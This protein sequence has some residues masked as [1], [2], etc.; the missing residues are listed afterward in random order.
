MGVHERYANDRFFVYL[1]LNGQGDASQRQA[2]A[3][4]ERTGHPLVW[5]NV[6]DI[7]HI[8]QEFFRWEIAIAV[9]GTI[10]GIDPFDRPDAETGKGKT[11]AST[12]KQS[13]SLVAE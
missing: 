4:L 13:R 7:W 12:K 9:A 3:A 8:G 5:I 11:R 10:I 2:V 6:K 1:E